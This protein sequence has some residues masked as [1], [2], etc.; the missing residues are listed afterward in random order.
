MKG[1]TFLNHEGRFSVEVAFILVCS[2]VKRPLV[3][4]LLLNKTMVTDVL[5]NSSVPIK[6]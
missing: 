2:W 4:H 6:W 3:F 1:Y 5:S